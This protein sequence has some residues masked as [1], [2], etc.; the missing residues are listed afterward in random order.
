MEVC[1]AEGQAYLPGKAPCYPCW[2]ELSIPDREMGPEH[3]LLPQVQ[4][5]FLVGHGA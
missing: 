4:K 1:S 5:Y 3:H 2:L